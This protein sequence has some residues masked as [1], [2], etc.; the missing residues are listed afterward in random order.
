[1]DESAT[2]NLQVA[3]KKHFVKG[4]TMNKNQKIA[5]GCG[6][7]GCL[8]LIVLIVAVGAFM[9]WRS[10]QGPAITVERPS[11]RSSG[12]SNSNLDSN[13]NRNLNSGSNNSAD[14]RGDSSTLSDNDR[15]KLFQAAGMTKDQELML[16]VMKEIGLFKADGTPAGDYP[17]FIKDHIAWAV[18]N[19]AFIT[20]VNT[21]EKAK[22]YVDQH[23]PQ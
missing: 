7:A 3:C 13:S 12:N 19:T 5:I 8:G 11:G 16:K 21:P 17:Q 9:Y 23:L 18:N 15:H 1:L 2:L 4:K 14:S 6:A 22:A 20:S 10:L